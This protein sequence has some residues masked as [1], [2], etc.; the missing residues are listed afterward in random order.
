MLFRSQNEILVKHAEWVQTF[1]PKYD[2]LTKE[3][4]MH[5]L[6]QEVGSVFVNVLE[7]AGVFKCTEEGRR[8]FRKFISEL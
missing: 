7:D 1:L 4:V 5:I 3:N 2:A 8:A 6:E